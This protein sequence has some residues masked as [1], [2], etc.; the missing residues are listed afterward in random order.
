MPLVA[1]GGHRVII[2]KRKYI[3]SKYSAGYWRQTISGEGSLSL[4]IPLII[5][6]LRVNLYYFSC[7]KLINSL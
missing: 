5:P 7:S 6:L 4:L 3:V 1:K 2:V